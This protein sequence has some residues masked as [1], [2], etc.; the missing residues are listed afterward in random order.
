MHSTT[1]E[2]RDAR[3]GDG[4]CHARGF[5][6]SLPSRSGQKVPADDDDSGR[7]GVD[8]NHDESAADPRDFA[9]VIRIRCARAH[10]RPPARVNSSRDFGHSPGWIFKIL[11]S[12]RAS[13]RLFFSL[14]TPEW[15]ATAGYPWQCRSVR[16]AT[17]TFPDE[18]RTQSARQG[19]KVGRKLLFLT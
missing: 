8:G 19:E 6:L 17:D 10:A 2:N 12:P 1:L 15:P 3:K 18:P 5:D 4:L 14:R 11:R 7:L 13:A 9:R 16:K